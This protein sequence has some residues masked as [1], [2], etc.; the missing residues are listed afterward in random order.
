VSIP[1]RA[2]A[3]ASSRCGAETATTTDGSPMASAPVRCSSQTARTPGQRVGEWRD[4]A[5]SYAAVLSD[6]NTGSDASD[7]NVQIAAPSGP[8]PWQAGRG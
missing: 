5:N 4:T 8:I 1:Y 2:A 6:R 3:N 7:A